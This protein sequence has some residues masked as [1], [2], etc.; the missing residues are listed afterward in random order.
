[1]LV[2][3]I[4]LACGTPPAPPAPAAGSEAAAPAAPSPAAAVQPAQATTPAK[5]DPAEWERVVAAAK[6]EGKVACGC[7]PIPV[8]REFLVREFQGAYPEIKLEHTPGVLP[9]FPA[10][11]EAERAAGQYLWDIYLWGP[12][13][14]VYKLADAGV[15]DPIVPAL[16]LPE[17]ANPEVWGG[18]D[19]ALVDTGRKHVFGFWRQLGGPIKYN[20]LVIPP[21]EL[22]G[23]E[24][25]LDPKYKGKIVWWDP[26]IGGGG[27]EV[28]SLI[29]AR[30]GEEKLRTMVV[31]QQPLFVPNGSTDIAERMVRGGYLIGVGAGGLTE[32]LKPYIDAGVQLDIRDAGI[33]SPDVA[34]DT[35]NYGTVALFNRAPNPNAAKV[36]LNWL[37]T[38]AT[39]E[40]M[41]NALE[42]NS[43]RAD[44]PPFDTER[45]PM[46]GVKYLKIQ[47][48]DF[49]TKFQPQVMELVRQ[50]RPQ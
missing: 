10:R 49:V 34:T 22:R 45:V 36:F 2:A 24:D 26:R 27:V 8:A 48:Q 3:A 17:V 11:V 32:I 1:M 47:E 50:W 9:Q 28:A 23:Y 16:L 29:Y 13:I 7:P 35:V 18:W 43:R 19:E 46:P 42:R 33:R 4:L 20:A 30:L 6:Q 25:L 37:L 38:R 5:P 44:V 14:E 41:A 39:Q 21:G 40:K 12:G 31:D 15:F